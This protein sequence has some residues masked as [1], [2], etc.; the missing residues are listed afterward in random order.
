MVEPD[1]LMLEHLRG[2]RG[3]MAKMAEARGG[4]AARFHDTPS[5]VYTPSPEHGFD[6][7]LTG[8]DV[9]TDTSLIRRHF[10][11][12]SADTVALAH[13]RRA[14]WLSAQ[15]LGAVRRC[16]YLVVDSVEV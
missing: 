11:Y 1:N 5:S 7:A 9:L 2:I 3:D 12:L 15:Q 13:A 16:A 10:P 8:A 4:G 14:G 6:F